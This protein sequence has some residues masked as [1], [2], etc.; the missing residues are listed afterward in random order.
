VRTLDDRRT[1]SGL[2]EEN[3]HAGP[4]GSGGREPTAF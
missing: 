2:L 3:G 1:R 4:S